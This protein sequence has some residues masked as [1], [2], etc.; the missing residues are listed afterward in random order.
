MV[1]VGYLPSWNY[2]VYGVDG[3]YVIG[4]TVDLPISKAGGSCHNQA[5]L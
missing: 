3:V 5:Q 2:E 1:K 4:D